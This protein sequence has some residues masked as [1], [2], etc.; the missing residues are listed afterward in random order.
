MAQLKTNQ[1]PSPIA[2]ALYE[3]AARQE[4][5]P[6]RYLGMSQIGAPCDRALWYQF[7]QY[8]PLPLEGR[9]KM[10][11]ELG[12]WVEFLI[13]RG[14]IDSGYEVTHI[15]RRIAS[16]LRLL[17]YDVD[18][19]GQEAF[20]DL[21]GLFCGHCDGHIH[22]VTKREHILECKSANSKKFKAFQQ[23]GTHKVY[24]VYYCQCQLY[25]GYSGLNRALVVVYNKETSEIFTE[26]IR[27]IRSDFEALRQR[28]EHIISANDTPAQPFKQDSFDCRYCDYRILC[29]APDQHFQK[30]QTCGSCRHLLFDGLYPSCTNFNAQITE[31]GR[32]GCTA[33]Q[34]RSETPF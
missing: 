26:R 10:L 7:R 34:A 21:N 33:W 23:F 9:V 30:W 14:L 13:I 15:D 25:M 28:A 11:F 20:S 8:S 6:R 4:D 16:V 17:G 24:P 19:S 27:F 32:S 29:Y 1:D 31:W 18:D 3:A 22:G 12:N 5:R 2:A